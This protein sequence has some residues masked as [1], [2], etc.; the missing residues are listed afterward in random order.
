MNAR[1][2][3]FTLLEVLIALAIV[4]IGLTAALRASGMGTEGVGEYRERL[5]AQ[6]VAENIAA[7]RTALGAW[8]ATG[9]TRSAAEMGGQ[10]FLVSEEVKATPN[11]R[12]RRLEIR[13]SRPEEPQRA[14]RRLTAFL[15]APG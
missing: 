4:A 10:R 9:V 11:P 7:E 15:I 8:P 3:G 5:L 12:F 13:V 6:W 14:L 1:S 2:G